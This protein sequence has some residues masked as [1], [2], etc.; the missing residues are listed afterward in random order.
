[1]Y[2]IK[3]VTLEKPQDLNVSYLKAD[4]PE[5][6]VDVLIV[7][8]EGVYPD[9]SLGNKHA[10]YLKVMTLKG[11]FAFDPISLL[12]DFSELK[13][14]WGNSLL[15]VFQDVSS[16]MDREREKEEPY[17]PLSILVSDKSKGGLLS[18]WGVT[19]DKM[20]DNMFESFDKALEY[21]SQ[22]AVEWMDY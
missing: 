19:E 1:M 22:K 8:V 6:K 14:N 9:G 3:E 12:L 21:T 18:L 17:F 4:F 5:K 10:Q 15:G 16:I 13:Y 11:L 20:P 7:K 2:D